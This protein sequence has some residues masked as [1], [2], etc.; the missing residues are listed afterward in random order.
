MCW[1]SKI[2]E[3]GQGIFLET[4]TGDILMVYNGNIGVYDMPYRNKYGEVIG[5]QNKNYEQ[6]VIDEVG[7]GK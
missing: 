2:H 4:L 1:H 6:F 5:K 7:G 3:G